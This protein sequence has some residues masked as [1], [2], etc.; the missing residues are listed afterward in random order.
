MQ[1]TGWDNDPPMDMEAAVGNWKDAAAYI[2]AE[3]QQV[4][5]VCACVSGC[6]CMRLRVSVGVECFMLWVL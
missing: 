2:A 5:C 1:I 3:D 4:W 6:G